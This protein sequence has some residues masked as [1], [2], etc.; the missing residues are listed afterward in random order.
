M[1]SGL[2]SLTGAPRLLQSIARDGIVPFLQ[3]CAAGKPETDE[4]TWSV[5]VTAIICWIGI[6]IAA[7]DKYIAPLATLFFLMCY[8]FVNV[9]CVLQSFLQAPSWRPKLGIFIKFYFV[10]IF[11]KICFIENPAYASNFSTMSQV[12]KVTNE[13][14]GFSRI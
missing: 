10:Y 5:L 1:N 2:Q 4:P 11:L 12:S 9:A 7:L 3:P 8:L 14:T 13:I 6:L